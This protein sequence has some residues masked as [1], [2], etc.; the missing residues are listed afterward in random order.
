LPVDLECAGC[1]N[2]KIDY[3]AIALTTTYVS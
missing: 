3:L 1:I 2:S